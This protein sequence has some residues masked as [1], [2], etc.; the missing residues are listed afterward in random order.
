M[1]NAADENWQVLASLFPEGW[2]QK[3]RE[4]GAI[5]RQ[6]GITVPETLLRLFLLHVGRGYSLCET[7]VRARESGL[8]NIST[9]G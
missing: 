3:A 5:K 7:S 9:V 2:D 8:A 4:T 6:R 1:D